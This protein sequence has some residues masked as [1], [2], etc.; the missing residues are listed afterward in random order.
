MQKIII[1]ILITLIFSLAFAD[2]TKIDS[3]MSISKDTGDK[4]NI[5]YEQYKNDPLADKIWGIEFNLVRLLAINEETTTLS[6]GFSYFGKPLVEI[7]VPWYYY[8]HD[9]NEDDYWYEYDDYQVSDFGYDKVFYADG[10]I[11]FF[12]GNTSNGFFMSGLSR[13]AYLESEK[14]NYNLKSTFKLGIGV[15]IG[16]RSFSY[17][18]FNWGFSFSMGRYLTGEKHILNK[19]TTSM[20][21]L[22]EATNDSEIFYDIEILKFGFAF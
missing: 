1:L 11:R 7:Y 3:L 16:W 10:R 19:G 18:G 20:F 14:F 6:G 4:V 5:L 17:R 22:E 9:L 12:T 2:D 8:K 13:L 15:G 21:F